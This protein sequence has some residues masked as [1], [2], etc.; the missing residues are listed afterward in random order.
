[1]LGDSSTACMIPVTCIAPF[2]AQEDP[3][4]SHRKRKKRSLDKYWAMPNVLVE[5]LSHLPKTAQAL[6]IKSLRWLTR[7]VF[8][9]IIALAEH[10][11][12]PLT[13]VFYYT[14]IKSS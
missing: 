6:P 2:S 1:M 10:E 5:F 11:A 3:T 4:L 9:R 12:N 8:L 7:Q 13:L 14:E